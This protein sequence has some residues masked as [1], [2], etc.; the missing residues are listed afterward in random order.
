MSADV[1]ST[2]PA[3]VR[4]LGPLMATAVV[5]GTV[6]GSGIFL[7]PKEV[8]DSV[9]YFGVAMLAWVL[10]GVL[11]LLGS[12]AYAE[13]A[14]L[15]PRAGGNY[16]F[17]REGYGRLAGF[18]FGWV[19]FW[20]I[21]GA[22]L[23]A[24]AT[25]FTESLAH[26]L[27]ARDVHIASWQVR[28]LTVGVILG[29]ALVNVRGVRWGGGLQL[30]ITTVKVGSL[31]AIA[32]LPFVLL[33]LAEPAGSV[34]QVQTANLFPAWPSWGQIHLA[35]F[36]SALLAV[37][38]AYHGWMNIAPVAQ[39]VRA[40]QR[41]LPLALLAGT[42]TIVCLYLGANLAYSLVIPQQQLKGLPDTTTAATDFSTRLLGPAGA[43]A[44]SAAIMCS[45][46][47]ALNGN[48]LVG[49]RLLYALGEDGLAPRA[50]G[51]VHPRYHTPA[52]AILVLAAWAALLV[53][54]GAIVK[55]YQLLNV[56]PE[57]TLFTILTDFAMFG[58]VIFETLALSTIF[59]F[60]RRFPN[61]E[62]PYRCPGYPLVP[63]VYIA[64]LACVAGN[65]F[66]EQRTEAV[67]GLAFIAVGAGVYWII[68]GPRLA[69]QPQMNPDESGRM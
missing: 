22:S 7:K 9:P 2:R 31:L 56:P 40:P 20:I 44:A 50:L 63:A 5:I 14:V 52:L 27:K 43:M 18:L 41:N 68:K 21:R 57:K 51:A 3:L 8:A 67:V 1:P 37:L 64:V 10:G 6:I 42:G 30:L 26:I 58:A 11:A 24:L 13:V 49:P 62:R 34:G 15:Y 47:G 16:V 28:G 29:L 45:V 38:W 25:A 12:L 48:L 36:G 35:G 53:V 54:A 4:A 23:A 65:M 39:E 46:F 60:R 59:V 32:A 17:L 33:G 55:S 61:V 66:F 19:D 69:G